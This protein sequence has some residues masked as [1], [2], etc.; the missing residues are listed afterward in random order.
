VV[1]RTLSDKEWEVLASE[2]ESDAEEVA[3][4]ELINSKFE[5][6]EHLVEQDK[7]YD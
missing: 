3:I 5:I 1:G 6:I 2:V 7:K 4:P